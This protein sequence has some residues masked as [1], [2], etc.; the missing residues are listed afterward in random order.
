LRITDQ[1]LELGTI[2]AR[3]SD[4]SLATLASKV[5]NDSGL[6]VRLS[7]G[8]EV[9]TGTFEKFLHFFRDEANWPDGTVPQ[10]AAALLV[11]FE[12]IAVGGA[13]STVKVGENSSGVPAQGVAA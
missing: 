2:W 10:A 4:R 12:N 3:V 13:S 9:N 5:A 8:K 6:F 1:L 7:G 11:N